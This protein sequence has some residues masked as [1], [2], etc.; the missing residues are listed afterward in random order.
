MRDLDYGIDR[1]LPRQRLVVV[2]VPDLE[3]AESILHSVFGYTSFRFDQR[4]IIESV[5][6]KHDSLV[7][8]PTGGGKSLCYQI[9]ALIFD[10]VTLVISPL[11]SLM[12]DQVSALKTAG[13]AALCLNSSLAL[14]E[15]EENVEAIR[16]GR[17]KLIYLAPETLFLARIQA[18]LKTI[19]VD[20]LTI[21][22][23]H[24]ISD[25]GHDF[26]PEYRKLVEMRE[27]FPKAVT[28]ALTATATHQVRADIKKQLKIPDSNEFVSS[29][30]R[31]NLFL[32][33][34]RKSNPESQVMGILRDH[35]NQSGIIYCFSKNQVDELAAMLASRGF[36]VKP[37]H[38]GLADQMRAKN[39]EL[40]IR[41]DVQIIVA[42]IAF[43]MGINKPNVRFVIHHDLPKNIESYYQEIGRAG[44]DGSPAQCYLLYSHSDSQKI[45]YFIGQ[46]EE[47]ERRLALAQLATLV[48]YAETELCRRFVLLRYFGET[49]AERCDAC[50]VCTGP[51]K[52]KTDLTVPAQKFMSC[53]KKS[54]ERFGSPHV[55]DILRGAK[56]KKIEG[57]GHHNLSTYGIGKDFSKAAW[58]NL[59]RQLVQQGLLR[60]DLEYGSLSLTPAAIPVLKGEKP[61]LG[62]TL[63]A[64][65]TSRRETRSIH[66]G[67]EIEYNTELFEILRKKRKELADEQNLAPYMIFADKSLMEM[68]AKLPQ[69]RAQFMQIHGV[70]EVKWQRYGEAF[71]YLIKEHS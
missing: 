53:V 42:T 70:G 38:A 66:K 11:I 7:I 15:Y 26:R 24:C 30:D 55:S 23:A 25:W 13:V 29:F 60:Q 62:N 64:E 4:R 45:K 19:K 6:A 37:Y 57:Y 20:C 32:N 63:E 22:E 36:S 33:V 35:E 28:I 8:M 3:T 1:A 49:A 12:T 54:G 46:K 2:T 65:T 44:R 39:Q 50:D 52:E 43:G 47:S 40:F 34:L 48:D 56:T 21:D 58:Q 16:A 27:K 51:T 10:G 41:D 61:F 68:A 71:L 59:S 31:K 69:T 9:P 67:S 17:V 14:D 18:M 5:L